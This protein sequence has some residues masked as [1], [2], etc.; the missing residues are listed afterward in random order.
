MKRELKFYVR[1]IKIV[2]KCCSKC[3][4]VRRISWKTSLM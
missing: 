4:L 1:S 2:S 3:L